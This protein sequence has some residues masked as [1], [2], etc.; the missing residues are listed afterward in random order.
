VKEAEGEAE[1]SNREATRQTSP[2]YQAKEARIDPAQTLEAIG[3]AVAEE[4]E[5]E[6]E[7]V[8]ATGIEHRASLK[9]RHRYPNKTQPQHI[10]L[11]SLA[12]VA[13]LVIA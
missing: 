1:A 12:E 3:P 5:V 4:G 10:H 9:Q 7:V 6:A 2:P 13:S 8:A 11:H